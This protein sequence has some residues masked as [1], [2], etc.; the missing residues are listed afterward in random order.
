MYYFSNMFCSCTFRS[1]VSFVFLCSSP[2]S[3]PSSSCDYTVECR[4]HLNTEGLH[5]P[6]PVPSRPGNATCPDWRVFPRDWVRKN[7]RTRPDEGPQTLGKGKDSVEYISKRIH[8]ISFRLDQPLDLP[9][10]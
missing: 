8:S 5:D 1:P 9:G 10:Y 3:P 7:P 6:R 4:G 2:N